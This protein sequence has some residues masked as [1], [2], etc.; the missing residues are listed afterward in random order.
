MMAS[1]REFLAAAAGIAGS[2]APPNIVLV[3]ADDLGYGDLGCFGS[4]IHRTPHLDRL[5]SEGARLTNHYVCSP[6][7]SPSRAGL[8]TGRYPQRTGVT[9]V[10]RDEHDSA[11][12]ALTETTLAEVLSRAGYETA[13]VGKW[14]LG[15]G[16]QY[17]PR[18]RGFAHF[19]GFLSGTIDYWTHLSL[20]GGARGQRV[21][22]RDEAPVQEQGYYQD[23]ITREAV[24]F[25]EQARQPFFLFVSSPMPHLPLQAPKR[26]RR[27][28]AGLDSKESA[29]YAA[30]VSC[31][32][33]S[34][35][36]L[37]AAL[38]RRRLDAS[39]LVVFLSDNGWV[40]RQERY[41]EVGSNGPLRGGKYEL[42]EGGIRSPCMVRWKGRIPAG[43]NP[44]VVWNL[45]WLPALAAA[46][47]ARAP[48]NLDGLNILPVLQGRRRAPQRT[49]LWGFRDELVG[50]PQSYA[51]RRGPWKYLRVGSEEALFNLEAD[52]GETTDQAARQ[53]RVF[54][55]LKQEVERWKLEIEP[56]P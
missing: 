38:E 8:L 34:V 48:R 17:R 28:Y 41:A 11:G 52:E 20:G 26:W 33:D 13:L 7:C 23:L 3:L 46:S 32:D 45:D 19:Y 9:G 50:T 27:L 5:A 40:K 36:Q 24:R 29:T 39:T 25:L 51:A 44:A 56:R 35:G 55:R 1:R 30:M 31:L 42:T 22:Y 2:Q 21:T 54:Q 15:L 6:V 10:L 18:G 12:L 4:L 14:H 49:L 47:G 16:E 43:A 37:L 53:P